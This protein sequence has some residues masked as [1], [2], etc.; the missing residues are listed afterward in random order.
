M[1]YGVG[2][3][4]RAVPWVGLATGAVLALLASGSYLSYFWARLHFGDTA[5]R[6]AIQQQIAILY[7]PTTPK[8]NRVSP[9]W[10]L[11]TRNIGDIGW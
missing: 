8:S 10:S 3:I 11:T 7:C 6:N 2:T 1:G 4:A 5:N 9:T